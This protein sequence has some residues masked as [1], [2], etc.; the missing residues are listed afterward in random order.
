MMLEV[1]VLQ[2][3]ALQVHFAQNLRVEHN[4]GFEFFNLNQKIYK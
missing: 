1:H 3:D 4:I 2:V